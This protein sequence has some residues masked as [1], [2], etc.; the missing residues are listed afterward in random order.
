MP[1]MTGDGWFEAETFCV[2]FVM[3]KDD[4]PVMC[5]V[6]AEALR[7]IGGILLGFTDQAAN[8]ELFKIYRTEIESAAGLKFD[9]GNFDANGLLITSSDLGFSFANV[10]KI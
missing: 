6:T 9:Q 7:Y 5:S 4:Q 2:N 1:L 8:G 3:W 10:G